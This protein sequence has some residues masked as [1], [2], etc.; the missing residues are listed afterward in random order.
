[1]ANQHTKKGNT[2]RPKK[3]T[4]QV[5][6][7]IVENAGRVPLAEMA[8]KFNSNPGAFR[9]FISGLRS[10]GY[11]IPKELPVKPRPAGT[12]RETKRKD[13]SI[14][15]YKKMENGTWEEQLSD[16]SKGRP[17]GSGTGRKNKTRKP[18]TSRRTSMIISKDH[19]TAMEKSKLFVSPAVI[20]EKD[21]VK[22]RTKILLPGGNSV[23]CDSDKVDATVRYLLRKVS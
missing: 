10:E 23:I 1:M 5:I 6:A 21:D 20:K 9:R 3:Y 7:W 16:R 4:P 22:E 12:I 14:R 17:T 8:I 15:T 18:G 2:G 19:D 13:G 11:K